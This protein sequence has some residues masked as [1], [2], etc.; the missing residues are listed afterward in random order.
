MISSMLI[1]AFLAV[2]KEGERTKGCVIFNP[3]CVL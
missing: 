3:P 2:R 1:K